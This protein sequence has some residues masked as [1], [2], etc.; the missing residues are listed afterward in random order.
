VALI[1]AFFTLRYDGGGFLN[2]LGVA[3]IVPIGMTVAYLSLF[4]FS[5]ARG[6][7]K[8]AMFLVCAMVVIS[9]LTI[10]PISIGTGSFFT[11]RLSK[12][13][14]K[15]E[16]ENPNKLWAFN[17]E[18]PYSNYLLA[19]GIRSINTINSYP[20]YDKWRQIDKDRA[21]ENIYN[22]YA[23][24]GVEL[25]NDKTDILLMAPDS[26]KI[27]LNSEDAKRM[28]IEY[29]VSKTDISHFGYDLVYND[30]VSGFGIYCLKQ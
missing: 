5:F 25:T 30:S 15:I 6:Y 2:F 27:I 10:N 16:S 3:A 8:T 23:H 14:V 24:T 19:N 13:I 29:I 17:A 28:D 26:I 22:R 21:Y 1:V 18:F 20:D 4:S 7:K 11:S 9:G 12:E